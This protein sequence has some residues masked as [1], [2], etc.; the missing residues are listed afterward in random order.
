MD[1]VLLKSF[2]ESFGTEEV[3]EWLHVPKAVI[4]GRSKDGSKLAAIS[5][6]WLKDTWT[7]KSSFETWCGFAPSI[8]K[9]GTKE[10]LKAASGL[11]EEVENVPTSGFKLS[12]ALNYSEFMQGRGAAQPTRQPILMP[13]CTLSA[14]GA[15]FANRFAYTK[16]VIAVEDPRGWAV[17][18]SQAQVVKLLA[19]RACSSAD[20]L[21]LPGPLVYVFSKDGFTIDFPDGELARAAIDDDGVDAV[22]KAA[23]RC[24]KAVVLEVGQICTDVSKHRQMA[25]LG[26]FPQDLTSS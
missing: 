12:L 4:V 21:E 22:K 3:A 19:E 18:V 15:S 10:V 1:N 6:R 16:P 9:S 23:A 5:A 8:S 20:R 14:C 17:M 7:G 26:M 24:K 13:D 11:V 25:Y 2:G